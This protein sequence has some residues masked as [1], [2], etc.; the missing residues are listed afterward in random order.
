MFLNFDHYNSD[1]LVSMTY[2]F[3][4]LRVLRNRFKFLC[5]SKYWSTPLFTTDFAE[6]R[7]VTIVLLHEKSKILSKKA[8]F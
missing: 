2:S 3:L 4:L 8:K 5:H 1:T 6:K 7:E